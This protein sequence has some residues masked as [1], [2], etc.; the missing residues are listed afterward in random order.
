MSK[1]QKQ[2]NKNKIKNVAGAMVM[3]DKS[4]VVCGRVNS[5]HK[6]IFPVLVFLEVLS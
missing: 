6:L 3:E 2:T 5:A 4:M 1:K